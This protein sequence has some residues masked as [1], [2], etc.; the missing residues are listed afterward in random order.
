LIREIEISNFQSLRKLRVKLGRFTVI[1]G[2]TGTGKSAIIR[3][4][5]LLVSNARGTSYITRGEKTAGVVMK[6]EDESPEGAFLWDVAIRRGGQ[7]RYDLRKGT[8]K[9]VTFTKLAGKVPDQVTALL[10]LGDVHFAGQF[11]RPYLLDAKG[12][13]VSRVLGK[14]TNVTLLY[15]A[16]QE[17]NRR[18]LAS[19]ALLKGRETDLA[20]LQQQREAYAT[21][22]AEEAAVEAAE[23]AVGRMQVLVMTRE[24]LERLVFIL[25]QAQS[26]AVLARQK[27]PEPPSLAALE[28]MVGQRQRLC[29]LLAAADAASIQLQFRVSEENIATGEKRKT[30]QALASYTAQWGVCPTCGQPVLKEHDH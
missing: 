15:R 8:G 25:M 13:E 2:R 27:M 24:R 6:G 26:V 23:A 7:D 4:V 20:A 10:R 28:D 11:D 3:A 21:L 14:L 30:E 18:R 29:S 17:A 16:A 5:E 9:P 1:T 19:S 12:S 22:P